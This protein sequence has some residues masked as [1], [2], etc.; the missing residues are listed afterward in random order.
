MD[1]LKAFIQQV[2]D[3]YLT[4]LG[5]K[6]IL[7]RAYKDLEQETPSLLLE[8]EEAKVTLREESCVLR[9]PLAESSCS[10]P[11]RS[12]CRHV[13]TA[14]LW[15]KRELA[16]QTEAAGHTGENKKEQGGER[17]KE[18]V[19]LSQLLEMPPQQLKR[20]LGNKR[21]AL[22]LSHMQA[23]HR[24]A[25]E[26][27]SVVTV[28]LP[29]E[30]ETVKLLEPVSY[31][32]CTCHSKELCAHK[33]QAILAY[34][35]CKNRYS[36]KELEGLKEPEFVWD[37]EQADLACEG[38]CREIC[39]QLCIGLSRASK[40]NA[41]S[42]LRLSVIAHRAALPDLESALREAG[43]CYEQYFSRSAAF[44][45]GAL[46]EKLLAIYRRAALLLRAKEQE[47]IRELAGVFRDTYAPVGTL[48]LMGMGARAFSG[49]TGYEGEIYYFLETEQK[50]WYTWTDARPTFYEGKKTP[51]RGM[52]NAQAPWGL[53]CSRQQ[54]QSLVFDLKNA[55]AAQG[56]RL[57][58]SMESQGEARGVRSPGLEEIREAICW[59]YEKMILDLQE[60]SHTRERIVLAG[61]PGWEEACFDKVKQRFR[62]DIYDERDRRLSIALNYTKEEGL[63]INL[64]ERLERRLRKKRP[65]AIVFLGSFYLDEEGRPCLYPI[66]FFMIEDSLPG[67]LWSEGEQNAC[68]EE[69]SSLPSREVIGSMEQ[70]FGEAK[71]LLEDLFVSGLSSVREETL[72]QCRRLSEEGE[73]MGLHRAGSD[74]QAV[75]QYFEGRRHRMEFSPE[76]VPE[77]LAGLEVYISA[78][79]R[80]LLR[81]KALRC[82][83]DG[84]SKNKG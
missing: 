31:C 3:D 48:H 69:E 79:R 59:D 24:P 42:L 28:V 55:R 73:Q 9:L 38:I 45:S 77:I 74:L 46:M 56:R 76:P 36:L 60:K 4:G 29:W 10:C 83:G 6:G 82:L 80:R 57:S 43:A 84:G 17:P 23:G 75:Y 64:L 25:M 47:E 63:I 15:M 19:L 53:N 51:K 34:Q 8:G 62:W 37:K 68:R 16:A 67:N 44:R 66:E 41:E 27:T 33:A 11:S 32:A 22:F 70:Y 65:K 61:A 40:E 52:E 7:K 49:K 78:C 39:R 72:R 18:P 20:S 14:V 50:A 54:L 1:N 26:E 30:K 58:A 12:I 2:D 71:G 81:D 21:Y 35:L 5:N 13:I